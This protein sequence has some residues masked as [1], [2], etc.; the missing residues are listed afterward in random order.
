MKPVVKFLTINNIK[1]FDD[2]FLYLYEIVN[3]LFINGLITKVV[4]GKTTLD[5]GESSAIEEI[6]EN[7]FVG[8]FVYSKGSVD[9]HWQLIFEFG[10]YNSS[11]QLEITISSDNYN[12]AIDN[13]YLES[14]KL[15]LKTS[16][17]NDWAEIVW[18]MD[19]DSEM[20]SIELY[21]HI[22]RAENLARQLINEIMTKEYG[23]DWWET[24][25]PLQIKNKHRAR[26]SGYKSTVPGFSNVN[27]KLM[28]IDIGDLISIFTLKDKKWIPAFNREI[29]HYLNDQ[30]EMNLE[31]I[32]GI[33]VKQMATTRDLWAEQFSKYLS[34][35]F[36]EHI[37]IFEKNRNH[38][39]H[40][41]LID[42]AAYAS[43]L[44]SIQD[45]ENELNSGLHK[46][47]ET[48]ISAEQ[49][50]AISEQREIER[51][52]QEASL[53]DIMESEAGIEIRSVEEI[54]E[55][56]DEQLYEFYTELESSL[57]F[58]N[59]IEFGEYK[60]ISDI[61]S[62]GV[63]FE[64]NY[65]IDD[66]TIKVCYELESIIDSQG[67]ESTVNVLILLGAEQISQP[68]RYI[69]GEVSFNS[70]QGNYMPETQ[71]EF[72]MSD[73]E[74]VMVCLVEFINE[75]FENKRE[76][77]DLQM[78]SI[79][80]DGGHSPLADIPCWECGGKYICV[81]QNYGNWG[82]CL[83][84]GAMNEIAVCSRCGCYFEGKSNEDEPVFCDNCLEFFRKE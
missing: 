42:R 61:K 34:N 8:K 59:D 27:E 5:F 3:K 54:I 15:A 72:N 73:L 75:H 60:N 66:E 47:T 6:D 58:R 49:R 78:Y 71:D 76:S 74:E 35:D 65:K 26:M 18:L 70:Y 44:H 24:Y 20:L 36:I 63:L 62:S 37:K 33:L 23:V 68:I 2:I 79:I 38:V 81:D 67:A 17:K 51:E 30:K 13:N 1:P 52:E 45:V 50:K 82:Q 56:Y 10:T 80:K 14:L 40:N 28:S 4:V 7:V 41:K 46:V 57:R 11:K 22:Y 43:I 64:I 16:I 69:N 83:N 29:S 21:P 55:L 19:K 32:H 25:V 77:V 53:H 84:C 39:V 48:V 12:F 9:T 31:T